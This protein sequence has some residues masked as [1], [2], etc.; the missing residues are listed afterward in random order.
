MESFFTT[1]KIAYE[2]RDI[3]QHQYY[4]E[5][6]DRFDGDIVPLIVFDNG[7]RVI[8]GYDTKRLNTTLKE[9]GIYPASSK[10]RT[11]R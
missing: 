6:R 2:A 9:L 3:Q 8:D 5:W 11:G 7:Y 10:K 1:R 4:R